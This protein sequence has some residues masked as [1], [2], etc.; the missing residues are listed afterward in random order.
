MPKSKS[1]ILFRC[2]LVAFLFAAVPMLLA[3]KVRAQTEAPE[4]QSDTS[5]DGEYVVYSIFPKMP[6]DES[7]YPNDSI[8]DDRTFIL[9]NIRSGHQDTLMKYPRSVSVIWSPDSK[10]IAV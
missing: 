8:D 2:T 7:Y 5:R 9:K 3:S 6:P 4:V 1:M 10:A